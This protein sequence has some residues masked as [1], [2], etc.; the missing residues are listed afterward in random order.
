MNSWIT[1]S[2]PLYRLTLLLLGVALFAGGAGAEDGSKVRGAH[3][4]LPADERTD[5]LGITV[6][7]AP[8]SSPGRRYPA[9][10]D[11]PT[12]PE[13][14]E[15]L[16]EFS[17]PNQSGELIDFHRDRGDSQAIVVFYRSVVW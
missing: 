5:D 17:L 9:T 7:R 8:V 6:T 15:R 10:F 2:S 16:P 4:G 3:E 1:G 13:V 12:G 11:F 14:G